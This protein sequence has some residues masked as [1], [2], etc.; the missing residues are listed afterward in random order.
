MCYLS[1]RTTPGVI[2]LF[3]ETCNTTR[4]AIKGN[5]D[6]VFRRT[7]AGRHVRLMLAPRDAGQV[8]WDSMIPDYL[9][10][11]EM[12]DRFL[13]IDPPELRVLSAF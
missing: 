4:G 6:E 11:E 13:A 5:S 3:Q 7:E 2:T 12:V 10:T 8:I 1:L 9:V